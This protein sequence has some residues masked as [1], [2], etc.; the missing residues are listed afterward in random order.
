MAP[1][2]YDGGVLDELFPWKEERKT[3]FHH[4][5]GHRGLK[6]APGVAARNKRGKI[7]PE[8]EN[9]RLVRAGDGIDPGKTV[10]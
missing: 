1:D 5:D 9:V 4:V 6:S 2:E 8:F 3:F 7:R 10:A